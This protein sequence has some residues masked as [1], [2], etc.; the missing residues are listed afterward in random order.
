MSFQ[1]LYIAGRYLFWYLMWIN[2]IYF[3]NE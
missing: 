1:Y 3:T 2:V